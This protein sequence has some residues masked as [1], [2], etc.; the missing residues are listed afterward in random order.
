MAAGY[1]LNLLV[2]PEQPLW[3]GGVL[4]TIGLAIIVLGPAV[5][6]LRRRW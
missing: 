6:L 1:L 2:T 5:P 3:N 4:Q